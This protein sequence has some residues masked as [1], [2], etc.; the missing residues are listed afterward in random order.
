MTGTSLQ[1][2]ASILT[3]IGMSECAF[4]GFRVM[5]M[6]QHTRDLESLRTSNSYYCNM[7][8]DT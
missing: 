2:Q 7:Q 6:R 5:F 3:N 4:D 8:Q 1:H